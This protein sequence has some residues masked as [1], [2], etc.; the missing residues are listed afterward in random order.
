MTKIENI[1]PKLRKFDQNWENLTK[2]AEI[3]PNPVIG[4][5][6]KLMHNS[7]LQ[8]TPSLSSFE[9]SLEDWSTGDFVIDASHLTL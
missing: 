5:A 8:C 4:Y 7:L 2:I 9:K 6:T 3:Y 1:W